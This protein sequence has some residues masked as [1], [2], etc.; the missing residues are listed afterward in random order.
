[1]RRAIQ[2]RFCTVLW[3]PRR[4]DAKARQRSTAPL[5]A[6]CQ[7]VQMCKPVLANWDWCLDTG[8]CLDTEVNRGR[9]GKRKRCEHD[10]QSCRICGKVKPNCD[11]RRPCP[12][13][14]IVRNCVQCS[15][16]P[17]QA[18]AFPC[19]HALHCR[20]HLFSFPCGQPHGKEKR[21]CLQC[22]ACQHGKFEA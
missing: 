13:G 2:R 18:F 17:Q 19:G 5:T 4:L 11:Q 21:Y 12:H 22:K 15:G 10:L 14:K 7:Y 16:S 9:R 6:S 20:Q 8:Q 3:L 1:M